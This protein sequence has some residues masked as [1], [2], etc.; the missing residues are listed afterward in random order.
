MESDLRQELSRAPNKMLLIGW[1][2]FFAVSLIAL[3]SQFVLGKQYVSIKSLEDRQAFFAK[4]LEEKQSALNQVRES[5]VRHQPDLDRIRA[6]QAVLRGELAAATDELR[7]T[8]NAA[9]TE[10]T[11]L[12]QAKADREDASLEANRQK[13]VATE[14]LSSLNEKRSMLAATENAFQKR[15]ASYNSLGGE[16]SLLKQNI[17]SLTANVA[18]LTAQET[19]LRSQ[20]SMLQ[21]QPSIIQALKS[22][23][24][25]LTTQ[26]NNLSIDVR[27][28]S[29]QKTDLSDHV[30]VL[31]SKQAS[32]TEQVSHNKALKADAKATEI[33]IASLNTQRAE[34]QSEVQQMA[35]NKGTLESLLQ[36]ISSRRIELSKLTGQ[37][38]ESQKISAELSAVRS[39]LAKV[40]Q[41][42][43]KFR[44]SIQQGSGQLQALDEAIAKKRKELGALEE[45]MR[46]ANQQNEQGSAK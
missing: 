6:E 7:I 31:L 33:E 27:R 13:A 4:E 39:Q 29:E 15:Q 46:I 21:K 45:K 44:G 30:T 23:V 8:K 41:D 12:K 25:V 16:E 19:S 18:S 35:S 36:S 42:F 32:L 28:L 10:A 3:L 11:T 1:A 20:V 9:E 34:L 40:E 5:I 24:D 38:Q 26:K 43:D 2:A 17:Q 37:L 22:K 14:I